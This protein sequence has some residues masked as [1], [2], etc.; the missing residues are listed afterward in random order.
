MSDPAPP[1]VLTI[2][3]SDPSGGAGVQADLRAIAVHGHVGAAVITAHTVQNTLGVTHV[4][5]VDARLVASQLAA[6]FA[7][8]PVA[9]IKIGMLGDA[10]V[11]AAVA[12]ALSGVRVPVVLDPVLRASSGAELLTAE[13]LRVVRDDLAPL[14]TLVTPNLAE[15]RALLEDE[16]DAAALSARLGVPVLLTGGHVAGDVVTDV[17]DFPGEDRQVTL[18]APRI[19]TPHD[20]GTGCLVSTSIACALAVGSS[21]IEAV[22]HGRACVRHGLA[23]ARKLG[24]GRGPVLLLDLPPGVARRA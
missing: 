19:P 14:A 21:V 10:E 7:D 20:H 16:P 2:A 4:A 15:A 24:Q 12:S 17:L 8:L 23:S 5:P 3:G 22:E 13:A 6:V 18:S 1:I 11:A 9:A